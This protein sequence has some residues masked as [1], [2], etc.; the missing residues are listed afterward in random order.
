MGDEKKKSEEI[1]LKE[2]LRVQGGRRDL[3]VTADA[4][5]PPVP[6]PEPIKKELKKK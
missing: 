5:P 3:T 4:S 2:Y 1:V 6:Q